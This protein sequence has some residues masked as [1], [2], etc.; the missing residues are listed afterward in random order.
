VCGSYNPPAGVAVVGN[1]APHIIVHALDDVAR[2][3]VDDEARAA[4]VVADN[5]VGLAA[6]F[7]VG[8]NVGLVAVDES[9]DDVAVFVPFGDGVEWILGRSRLPAS[10]DTCTSMY[11]VQ[12]AMRDDSVDFFADSSV[13][14]VDEVINDNVAGQGDLDEVAGNV[15]AAWLIMYDVPRTP[16]VIRDQSKLLLIL[17]TLA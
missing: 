2:V 17:Y 4:Q 8:G 7:H 3:S 16:L 10:R 12:E 13:L 6:L 11:I 1:L 5:A 14:A 15:V 9:G